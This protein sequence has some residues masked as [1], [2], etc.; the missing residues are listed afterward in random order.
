MFGG[1]S[2]KLREL[3]RDLQSSSSFSRKRA[4]EKSVEFG[5]QAVDLLLGTLEDTDSGVRKAAVLALRQI[6]D[7]RAVDRIT[8]L[9]KDSTTD[10]KETAA[11]ALLNLGWG[12]KD[13]TQRARI[14]IARREYDK[15]VDE[16]LSALPLLLDEF[17]LGDYFIDRVANAL[18]RYGKPAVEPLLEL[19]G[20]G[21][22]THRYFAA[23]T[24]GRIKDPRAIEPLKKLL[25]DGDQNVRTQAAKALENMGESDGKDYRE[26]VALR[27]LVSLK[28]DC[29][30]VS[31]NWYQIPESTETELLANRDFVM[32]PT[33]EML[34]DER[35]CVRLLA[36]R[37]LYVYG[38]GRAVEPLMATTTYDVIGR[39][40]SYAAWALGRIK[41]PRAIPALAGRLD[42]EEVA[43][44]AVSAMMDILEHTA[45]QAPAEI[46]RVAANVRD[47]AVIRDVATSC[48]GTARM[49]VDL[50]CP[51][52][53]QLARQELTRRGLVA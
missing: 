21:N 51:R 47:V 42:D 35:E 8:G 27:L 14:A 4:V 20:S 22:S 24:L 34:R 18:T 1:K 3:E 23:E 15:A 48:E 25:A 32:G 38:D 46:L 10:V 6:G 30:R 29:I 37:L 17:R 33:I 28:D 39:V 45:A 9:L 31:Q 2:R 16:G 26:S 53:R 52:V 11:D 41:D 13:P 36:A 50:D 5:R 12:A 40:R 7:P 44:W 49:K 19:L 43:D